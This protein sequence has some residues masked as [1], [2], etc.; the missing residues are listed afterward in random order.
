MKNVSFFCKKFSLLSVLFLFAFNSVSFAEDVPDI[1]SSETS[2]VFDDSSSGQQEKLTDT[3]P[4]SEI[5]I[6]SSDDSGY[7]GFGA[8]IKMIDKYKRNRFRLK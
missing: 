1:S 4:E 7:S 8:F 6:N 2:I 3:N 5:S